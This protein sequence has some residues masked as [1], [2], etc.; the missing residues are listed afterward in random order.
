MLEIG[1][2]VIIIAKHHPFYGEAAKIIGI[3]ADIF[4]PERVIEYHASLVSHP[5][6]VPRSELIFTTEQVT[7]LED[8][9]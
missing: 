5:Y 1:D 6:W 8:R 2:Y 9:R 7:K 4:Y 3:Q